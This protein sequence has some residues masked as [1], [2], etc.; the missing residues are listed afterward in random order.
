MKNKEKP[1][2]LVSDV[3]Q[4]AAIKAVFL[5]NELAMRLSKQEFEIQSISFWIEHDRDTLYKFHPQNWPP[6][7][8][9]LFR[10]YPPEEG[11]EH[12]P[13][14]IEISVCQKNQLAFAFEVVDTGLC[15]P[16]PADPPE[17]RK[18]EAGYRMLFEA[19]MLAG[20][21]KSMKG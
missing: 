10:M 9:V 17:H 12:H 14:M 19:G 18:D 6:E 1:R 13:Y 3:I 5:I 20:Q 11:E 15:V 16:F 7:S 21:N 8:W 4:T 2:L